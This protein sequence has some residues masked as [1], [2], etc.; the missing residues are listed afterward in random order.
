VGETSSLT[1][2]RL[3]A[4]AEQLVDSRAGRFRETEVRDPSGARSLIWSRYQVAGRNMVDHLTQ[5]LWYGVN[6]LVWKPPA[7]LVALRTP[8]QPDCGSARRSL[9]DFVAY[10]GT[11]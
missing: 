1:G 3:Q 7:G 2:E 5:Q 10:R 4:Q 9:Q 6:A 11:R 8:C